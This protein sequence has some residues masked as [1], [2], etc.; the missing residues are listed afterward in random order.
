MDP[1]P[2]QNVMY[3]ELL[4]IVVF[5]SRRWC[6][7]AFLTSPEQLLPGQLLTLPGHLTSRLTTSP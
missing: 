4:T 1:D 6:H 7:G 5:I 2:H 3:P